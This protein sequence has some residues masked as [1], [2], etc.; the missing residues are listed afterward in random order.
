MW[1]ALALADRSE[2]DAGPDGGRAGLASG[3]LQEARYFFHYEL[4]KTDAWLAVVAARDPTCRA[5]DE[6]WF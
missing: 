3:Q 1:L 6:A 5:M 4:P 2:L